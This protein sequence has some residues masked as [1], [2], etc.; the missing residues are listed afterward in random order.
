MST[1]GDIE[2]VLSD[3]VDFNKI[4]IVDIAVDQDIENQ[5]SGEILLIDHH[6]IRRDMNS[7]SVVFINPRF[8]KPDYYILRIKREVGDILFFVT[9]IQTNYTN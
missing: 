6:I 8:E 4:I 9:Y 3:L 7:D 2:D 1:Y 5:A